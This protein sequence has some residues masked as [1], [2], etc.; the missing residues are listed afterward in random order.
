MNVNIAESLLNHR[1]KDCKN[2]VKQCASLECKEIE[3]KGNMINIL[4]N[5]KQVE[6]GITDA[7]IKGGTKID[8]KRSE[9]VFISN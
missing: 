3:A 2:T 4:N 7:K 5:G 1:Q 9:G 6:K 8:N